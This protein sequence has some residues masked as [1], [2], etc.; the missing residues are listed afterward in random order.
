MNFDF[1]DELQRRGGRCESRTD[2]NALRR[3][4]EF[5]TENVENHGAPR[6]FF[7]ISASA[8]SHATKPVARGMMMTTPDGPVRPWFSVVTPYGAKHEIIPTR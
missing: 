2:R 5:T 7:A 3:C 6:R 8:S 4:K 1:S